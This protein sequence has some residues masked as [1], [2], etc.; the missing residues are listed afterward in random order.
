MKT[1]FRMVL[2]ILLIIMF[3]VSC[4]EEEPKVTTDNALSPELLK[5]YAIADSFAADVSD[6]IIKANSDF[7]LKIFNEIAKTE[8]GKN[9]MISPLSIS[10]A[11][12]MTT[13]G[14]SDDNL[15]EM[16]DV[17]EFA[18]MSMED[19]NKQFFNLL[20]SLIEVDKDLVLSIANSIWM[21][22][23]FA[24]A[25]KQAFLTI[26]KDQYTAKTES[27]DFTKST[28][29]DEIN[30]WVKNNTGDKIEKIIENIDPGVIMYLI[31][32][33]YFKAAWTKTFDKDLTI[34][35][36][37]TLSDTSVKK[38]KM[39]RYKDN[40][41]FLFYSTGFDDAGYTAVRLPYGRGKI[42]F[43]CLMP[44]SG[45]I[46]DFVGKLAQNGL[47]TYINSMT[48]QEVP[49]LLPKFKF[50]YKKSLVDI[51]RTLG[52]TKGFEPGGF[53]NLADNGNNIAI[54][55]ILHKTFIEVNEEGT[56]AAA[57]TAVEM[58]ETSMP[59]GF[60]GDKPFIYLIRDDRSKTILFMGK[61]EDPTVEK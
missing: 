20:S 40:N 11:L 30:N 53:L 7:A 43:Y 27:L 60:Y 2:M 1:C 15:K 34:D 4:S 22:D 6:D 32:A 46:N 16:K 24:P 47:E 19:V 58:K 8:N 9:L 50:E 3:F 33:I 52:M 29:K 49:V 56:E 39:M 10:I 31:N 48:E 38:V 42:A 54:S 14:A 59:M 44:H 26:M 36:D 5:K 17:M 35:W 57:V 12:A 13:N 18:D 45:T 61:I 41:K 51:F 25:V 37:F 21:S 23:A 28:A 55:D